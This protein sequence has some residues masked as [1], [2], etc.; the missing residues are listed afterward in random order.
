MHTNTAALVFAAA[1]LEN[2]FLKQLT[3]NGK[4]LAAGKRLK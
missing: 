3:Y 4:A 2:D 1:R